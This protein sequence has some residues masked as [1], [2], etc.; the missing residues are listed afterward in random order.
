MKKYL[1][2]VGVVFA[3]LLLISLFFSALKLLDAGPF[4]LLA[5]DVIFAPV[6][7]P[8]V[9]VCIVAFLVVLFFLTGLAWNV[10]KGIWTTSFK[11]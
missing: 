5:W 8:A 7:W 11:S 9:G 6:W 1:I 2:P 3:M 10:L 4:G